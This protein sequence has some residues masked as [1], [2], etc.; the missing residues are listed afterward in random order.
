MWHCCRLASN[1]N[2]NEKLKK[3]FFV[4]EFILSRALWRKIGVHNFFIRSRGKK[5]NRIM[6]FWCEYKLAFYGCDAIQ[7]SNI[8]TNKWIK[9]YE[10][11]DRKTEGHNKWIK[12]WQFYAVNEKHIIKQASDFLLFSKFLDYEQG[13]T[14][15]TV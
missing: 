11:K 1:R 3:N 6:H 12:F 15:L 4:F 8:V 14:Y 7:S 9:F 5:E 10:Q 2:K 13:Q